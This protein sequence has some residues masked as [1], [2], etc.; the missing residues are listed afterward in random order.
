MVGSK[1]GDGFL[2]ADIGQIPAVFEHGFRCLLEAPETG[3]SQKLD[4]NPVDGKEKLFFYCRVGGHFGKGVVTNPPLIIE[5]GGR[6]IAIA[7][8]V[9]FLNPTDSRN[10]AFIHN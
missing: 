5:S 2:P 4:L 8:V 6:D 7:N 1:E 9:V 10:V 3:Y